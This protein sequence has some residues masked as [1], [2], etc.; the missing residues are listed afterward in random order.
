MIE[1]RRI[2]AQRKRDIR[3]PNEPFSLFGRFEVRYQDGKWSHALR[4]FAP[5]DVR[6][7][8]FPDENYDFDQMQD[9]VF[10]GAY[11]SDRCVGLAILQPGFFKYMYL[12]DL[13]VCGAQR[14]KGI[15]KMLIQAASAVARESGYRGLYTQVRGDTPDAM[16]FSLSEDFELGGL[17][18]HVYRGTAQE[19]KA[20]V[21]FYRDCEEG[22]N[23]NH[24]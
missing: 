1:I 10:L 4:K 19:G 16:L 6:E 23:A 5:E 15:G 7:M 9:S 18:T 14:G 11:E 3:L 21:L 8:R 13:K 12:Y 22:E 24:A 2:D 17:D 20:D